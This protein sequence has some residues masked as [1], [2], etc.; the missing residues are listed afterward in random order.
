MNEYESVYKILPIDQSLKDIITG[1]IKLS[2]PTTQQPANQLFEFPPALIPLW[3]DTSMHYIAYWKHWF[4]NRKD[5][6]VRLFSFSKYAVEIAR[7]SMQ[8]YYYVIIDSL[9]TKDR[10]T[11]ACRKFA[12]NVGINDQITDRIKRY[13][14][15]KGAFLSSLIEMDE[16]GNNSPLDC[17]NETDPEN[18]K[19]DF[20]HHKMFLD[21]NTIQNICGYECNELL[22]E[23]IKKEKTI[24]LWFQSAN[25]YDNFKI[26]L[27]KNDFNGAWM[28][29]NT[30]GWNIGDMKNA[31]TRLSEKAG[32]KNFEI[33]TNAWLS[34]DFFDEEQ[35]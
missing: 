4:S 20:P 3:S 11:D 7:N 21:Q 10:V 6:F 2:Y 1:K 29:L 22:L 25:Q 30:S 14:S 12:N 34:L 32:N 17:Y 8:L 27:D 13:S 18:Y 23:R 15:E 5:T 28:C 16:F 33:L 9:S 19:L 35:I 31:L 24:P 26:L